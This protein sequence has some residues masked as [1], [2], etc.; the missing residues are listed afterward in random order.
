MADDEDDG[1]C[2]LVDPVGCPDT[3]FDQDTVIGTGRFLF[4]LDS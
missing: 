2:L 4:L 3:F 1:Q